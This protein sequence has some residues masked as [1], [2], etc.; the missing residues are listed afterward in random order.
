MLS[1]LSTIWYKSTI[2][3]FIEHEKDHLSMFFMDNAVT[4]FE[5]KKDE[6]R[7]KKTWFVG[8]WDGTEEGFRTTI[9]QLSHDIIMEKLPWNNY[10]ERVVCTDYGSDVLK[11]CLRYYDIHKTSQKKAVII[12]SSDHVIAILYNGLMYEERR[13]NSV[14]NT[15]KYEG[16][17]VI[18]EFL[19]SESLEIQLE[20]YASYLR[21]K[22]KIRE[23]HP[24]R[25]IRFPWYVEMGALIYFM[26]TLG[27]LHLQ[28][29]VFSSLGYRLFGKK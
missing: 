6:S 3:R 2:D 8:S 25:H 19:Q 7:L 20:M 10:V 21:D 29:S 12:T 27:V 9:K 5:K 26:H 28:C 1:I 11:R 17:F 24:I 23:M 16:K 18:S 15:L 4:A 13:E 22:D 14:Y